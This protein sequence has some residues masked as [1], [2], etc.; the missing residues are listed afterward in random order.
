MIKIIR[1]FGLC[2]VF[3][4]VLWSCGDGPTGPEDTINENIVLIKDCCN[5]DGDN[6]GGH[7]TMAVWPTAHQIFPSSTPRMFELS[8]SLEVI[9]PAV[10][11]FDLSTIPNRGVLHYVHANK[12]GTKLLYVR[13]MY[14]DASMGS[15]FGY[16]MTTDQAYT[17]RDSSYNISSAVFMA[18]DNY[19]IYYSY[20]HPDVGS[21]PGYYRYNFVSDQ[22][23][24]LL[25]YISPVGPSEGINGF[26]LHPNDHTLLIPLIQWD[27]APL[28]IEYDLSTATAET[29]DAGF[30]MGIM[31]ICL[32]VRYDHSG[33]KIL[34]SSHDYGSL[35]GDG[36]YGI[37]EESEIGILDRSTLT[38]L[39]LDVNPRPYRS[40]NVFPNWSPDDRHIIYGSGPITN[41]GLL[42]YYSIYALKNVNE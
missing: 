12:T 33:E 40:S 11:L 29:L 20:G 13:T 37:Q 39:V 41:D 28:L 42:G 3:G 8:D 4:A 31:R 38:K 18:D 16:D 21:N 2:L 34:Y 32:W 36:L 26:D 6:I 23:S 25:P 35:S 5:R 10:G 27:S 9:D 1:L 7:Y 30:D 14:S 19:C 15:L 17:I 22:D 24:L